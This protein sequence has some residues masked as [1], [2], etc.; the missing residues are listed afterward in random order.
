LNGKGQKL[1]AT[2]CIDFLDPHGSL[3]LQWPHL[4]I[5]GSVYLIINSGILGLADFAA[6]SDCIWFVG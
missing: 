1:R 4:T 5:K 3:V 6:S 2:Q